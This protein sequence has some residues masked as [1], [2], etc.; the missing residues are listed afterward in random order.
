VT[1]AFPSLTFSYY[2]DLA[3]HF[4][5]EAQER[6]RTVVLHSTSGGRDQELEVLRGLRRRLGD[7]LIFN[8]LLV[9]EDFLADLPHTDQPTVF[10]GEHVSGTALPQGSDYVQ[11]DNVQ[12]MADA[13]T[14]L[15]E[16]GRRDLAFV[17]GLGPDAP[18]HSSSVLRIEGF[19]RAVRE[20]GLNPDRA[21]VQIT[22][23]WHRRDGRSAAHRLLDEFPDLDA[24]VAANDEIALGVLVGLRD[25]GIRVPEDVAVI[26]Y[27]DTPES[28][29][30]I[31]ALSTISPD[32]DFLASTALTMLAE[33]IDGYDGPPRTVTTPHHLV[34]RESTRPAGESADAEVQD[35]EEIHR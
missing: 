33:R 10:I 13:T 8:P 12:A 24:V 17:G 32:K 7:G 31:P 19:R 28:P 9:G 2:A 20:H 5:D 14:H 26:G 30:A 29:F 35:T 6:D 15:L 11:I 21:P 25:R 1:L 3:Q 23:D 16:R 34:V 27:D 18:P 22:P 4:I